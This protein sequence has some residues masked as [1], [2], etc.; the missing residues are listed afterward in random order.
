MSVKECN[1]RVR[2]VLLVKGV[3]H[4]YYMNVTGVHILFSMYFSLDEINLQVV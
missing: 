2:G 4:E 1:R 3:L